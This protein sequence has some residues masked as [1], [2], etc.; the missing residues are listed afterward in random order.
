MRFFQTKNSKN[1]LS[2]LPY[3]NAAHEL[4]VG[5][6]RVIEMFVLLKSKAA[7]AHRDIISLLLNEEILVLIDLLT[8]TPTMFM[9]GIL[10]AMGQVIGT[11][12]FVTVT[13]IICYTSHMIL[14][15]I[16]H[17]QEI[18]VISRQSNVDLPFIDRALL[19]KVLGQSFFMICIVGTQ[20]W[21]LTLERCRECK[22]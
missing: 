18:S 1:I 16:F 21:T 13:L 14:Q 22:Q 3:Q 19:I 20:I 7:Q 9:L 10:K 6:L 8:T 17:Y 5:L 15:G 4:F 11:D 2:V 12:I